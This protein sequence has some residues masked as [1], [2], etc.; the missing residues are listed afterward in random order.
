MQR[1]GR[2]GEMKEEQLYVTQSEF[3]DIVREIDPAPPNDL[4]HSTM[5]FVDLPDDE[6]SDG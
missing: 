6:I 3:R 1:K 2:K 5:R 4:P